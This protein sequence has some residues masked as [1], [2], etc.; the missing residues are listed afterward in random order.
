MLSV[1]VQEDMREAA[2]NLVKYFHK[3]EQEVCDCNSERVPLIQLR[4]SY[5]LLAHIVKLIN[6]K[7]EHCISAVKCYTVNLLCVILISGMVHYPRFCRLG[8]ICGSL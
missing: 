2:N 7:K 3:H 6:S 1:E 5:N 4:P 8:F